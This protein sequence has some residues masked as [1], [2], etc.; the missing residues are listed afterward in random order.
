MNSLPQLGPTPAR[1]KRQTR[2]LLFCK[3]KEL[4]VIDPKAETE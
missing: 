4:A 1:V 3:N 2:T